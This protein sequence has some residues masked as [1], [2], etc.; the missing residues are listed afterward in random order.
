MNFE[1][2]IRKCEEAL[3]IESDL[4][5]YEALYKLTK[6]ENRQK[7]ISETIYELET[8]LMNCETTIKAFAI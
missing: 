1:M 5:M 3:E 7:E 2:I 4:R 6:D 8:N